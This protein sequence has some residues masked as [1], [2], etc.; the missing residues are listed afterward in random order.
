MKVN[1]QRLT[2]RSI[3]FIVR[4]SRGERLHIQDEIAAKKSKMLNRPSICNGEKNGIKCKNYWSFGAK[5]DVSNPEFVK[6]GEKF[7]QCTVSPYL[8]EFEGY[9]NLP[10]E[11]DRYVPDFWLARLWLMIV[12]FFTGRAV[13][14]GFELYD[15][16]T[17]DEVIELTKEAYAEHE[18]KMAKLQEGVK[19]PWGNGDGGSG[20]IQ[21]GMNGGVNGNS[22]YGQGVPGQTAMATDDQLLEVLKDTQA[23]KSGKFTVDDVMK[24]MKAASENNKKK[25]AKKPQKKLSKTVGNE[26][27]DDTGIFGEENHE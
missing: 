15:P 6:F 7:R 10:H 26:V 21:I 16:M 18:A 8:V 17:S 27:T 24:Q 1:N 13:D 23:V 19:K 25:S 5:V 22:G 14:L 11:C 9:D 12:R 3:V 2:L 4:Q 20:L